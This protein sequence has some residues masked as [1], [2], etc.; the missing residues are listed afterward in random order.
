LVQTLHL[1]QRQRISIKKECTL[2]FNLTMKASNKAVFHSQRRMLLFSKIKSLHH[3]KIITLITRQIFHFSQEWREGPLF[4]NKFNKMIILVCLRN[5]CQWKWTKLKME[6]YFLIPL[7]NQA[8]NIKVLKRVL[9]IAE[10]IL[11]IIKFNH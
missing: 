3:N 4:T 1:H 6:K 7:M 2:D 8:N 11:R 9:F 10:R 5:I